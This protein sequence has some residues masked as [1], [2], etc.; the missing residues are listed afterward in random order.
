MPLAPHEQEFLERIQS[1]KNP[2]GWTP[3]GRDENGVAQVRCSTSMGRQGG[4][5]ITVIKIKP[6]GLE[7]HERK[8]PAR[9]GTDGAG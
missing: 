4:V 2:L 5:K 6:E 7:Y 9:E 8:F 3:C 1:Q